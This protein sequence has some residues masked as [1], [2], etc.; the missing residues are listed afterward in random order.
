VSGIDHL[1]DTNVVIGL[2]K[3][4][5]PALALMQQSGLIMARTGVSQITR[6]EL[7]GFPALGEQEEQAARAFLSCCE[8]VRLSDDIENEAIRLR[9]HGGLKLPDAIVAATARVCGARL[10]TLDQRLARVMRDA[11]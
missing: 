2:L 1:L 11:F 9:R 10:L 5:E 6:M 4:A 3:G 8:V 7:L